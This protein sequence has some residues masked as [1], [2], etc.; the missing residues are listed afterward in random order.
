M[1][2]LPTVNM[3]HQLRGSGV[4][5]LAQPHTGGLRRTANAVRDIPSH[6]LIG[7]IIANIF[8]KYLE[9]NPEFEQGL[10]TLLSNNV[11]DLAQILKQAREVRFGVAKAL[12]ANDPQNVA[13]GWD[14]YHEAKTQ[15][16]FPI[17]KLWAEAAGDP[18]SKIC[19]WE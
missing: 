6:L 8:E 16:H 9:A 5:P 1:H 17:L 2:G 15:I 7:P 3:L 10:L 18:A 11:D 13:D 12:G 14:D 19:S 4:K